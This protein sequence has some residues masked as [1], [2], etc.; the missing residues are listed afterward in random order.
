VIAAV[1]GKGLLPARGADIAMPAQGRGAAMDDGADRTPLR[2]SQDGSVAQIAG[3][4]VAQDPDDTG[5]HVAR[6]LARQALSQTFHQSA[7]VLVSALCEMEI[8]HGSG[9]LLVT[10]SRLH[11]VET[12]SGFH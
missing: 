2:R 1:E 5:S 11:G 6:R 7:A 8:D 9:D 10:E 3:Q 4:E 12:G